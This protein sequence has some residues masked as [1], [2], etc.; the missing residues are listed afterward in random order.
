MKT[1]IIIA[2][3]GELRENL[4]RTVTAAAQVAPVCVVFD[5]NE[6]GNQCPDEVE[7]I[8]R[9]IR[10]WG[11]PQGCGM[12]R[13]E[14]IMTSEANLIVLIDGHMIL[15]KKWLDRIEE[16]H[17]P[18][19]N[20]LTCCRMQSYE[21]DGRT[22]LGDVKG[23]AFIAYKTRQVCNEYWP[24]PASWL[25]EPR[26]EGPVSAIMGACYAFRRKW[27][28]KIGEPLRILRAWGGD[29]EILSLATHLI[30]GHVELLPI[31]VGHI[32]MAN[33]NRGNQSADEAAAIWGNRYAILEALPIREDERRDLRQ[34]MKKT[35]RIYNDIPPPPPE[36]LQV[37]Q[38][39]ED[40]KVAWETLRE[41]GTV[42]ELTD[43]EQAACLGVKESS[44]TEPE[45][46]P[47]QETKTPPPVPAPA[48]MP[49]EPQIV[50]RQDVTCERC[51]AI[52]SFK[53]VRGRRKT[54]AFGIAYARCSH[55]N[56]KAQVR[57]HTPSGH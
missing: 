45:V 38:V 20:F 7:Q 13:H 1:E 51:G 17:T 32:Y 29:E 35:K 4:I 21:Q 41:N 56:H 43:S 16:F 44:I 30:G 49:E 8:A 42:R 46:A 26:T 6:D 48:H 19:H 11:P 54:G 34:W 2:A 12:A 31:I 18:R 53:Q 5:G 37:R 3:R 9:T 52:N 14:G 36:S 57:F 24:L 33:T 40:G 50:N 10:T 39:L 55:C 47:V 23:G 28:T 22:L 25:F 27:Y 15:R